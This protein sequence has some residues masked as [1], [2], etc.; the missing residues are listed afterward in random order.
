MDRPG[1]ARCLR[2]R[3]R[4][5]PLIICDVGPRDGLQNESIVLPPVVRAELI[6]RL[7]AARVPRVEAVSFV[8]EERVPQM[9]QAETVLAEDGAGGHA[10]LSGLV[11]N[12]RGL[13]RLLATRVGRANLTLAATDEFNRANGNVPFVEAVARVES[14]LDDPDD[15]P[16]T[17]TI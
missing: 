5:Y 7:L 2:E 16:A 6:E 11:L 3:T 15:M 10:K 9:A 8:R 12:A 17:V 4:V 13:Q 14:M 1:Y